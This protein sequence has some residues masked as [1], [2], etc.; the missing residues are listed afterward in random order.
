MH[1]P[2]PSTRPRAVAVTVL[3]IVVAGIVALTA[4]IDR[5]VA[6]PAPDAD[7]TAR[8]SMLVDPGSSIVRLGAAGD[9]G[10]GDSKAYATTAA[11]DD[12]DRQHEFDAVLL[13][14]D[15]VYETGDPAEI[16]AKV[17]DPF[18]PV[19][20]HGTRLIPV[21]GNHDVDSGNGPA[22]IAA[23]GM[24]GPWYSTTI[25]DVEIFALDSNR[26]GDPDQLA[27]LD[28]SLASSTADWKIVILH[29]PAYSAGSHGSDPGVQ[30]DFV[31]LLERYGVDLVL[32]G[33]DHDYQR[34]KPI[35]GVTYVVTGAAAKLRPTG[36][37]DF[38]EVSYSV[39]S[40][41]DLVVGT[42][43]IEGSAIDHDGRAIDRFTIVPSG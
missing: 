3:V 39:H 12:L 7:L 40:F 42:D 10:T 37:A 34:S 25:G 1:A 18:R 20:D 35:N 22:Q 9:S 8:D 28:R 19:L 6:E 16:T 33:H 23:L 27:W 36:S 5:G 13:L 29:H 4:R 26:S 21:L 14:G 32:S 15:N 43:R 30:R 41:V 2:R 38:T 24:P 11:M 17:F 31:P